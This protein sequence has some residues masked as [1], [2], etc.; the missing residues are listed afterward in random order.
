MFNLRVSTMTKGCRLFQQIVQVDVDSSAPADFVRRFCSR[1]GISEVGTK[2]ANHII[3]RADEL[4]VLCDSTPPSLV[5]GAI[6]LVNVE[7]KLGLAKAEMSE[8]CHVSQV[9]I[10]KCFKRL[11]EHR[12]RLIL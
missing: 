4:G 10:T 12:T 2:M 5:A 7:L 9:T 6:Q 1:L 8:A 3:E 11:N